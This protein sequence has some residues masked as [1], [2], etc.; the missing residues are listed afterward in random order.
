[1]KFKSRE[2]SPAPLQWHSNT[3]VGYRLPPQRILLFGSCLHLLPAF[4]SIAFLSSL[5][6]SGREPTAP[7]PLFLPLYSLPVSKRT[8]CP[9]AQQG[10]AGRGGEGPVGSVWGNL[11]IQ[12]RR[13]QRGGVKQDAEQ[14]EPDATNWLKF[15]LHI[16]TLLNRRHSLRLWDG[17]T[18]SRY[19]PRCQIPGLFRHSGATGLMRSDHHGT[20]SA[21]PD[22]SETSPGPPSGCKGL[23][24]QNK[25]TLL[26]PQVS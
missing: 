20:G 6:C 24:V 16:L 19:S 22:H 15:T 18:V 2:N 21:Q 7:L 17:G 1:M 4:S 13:P 23:R 10:W 9:A 26:A 12:E 25:Q 14:K 3:H 5:S 11:G 8:S